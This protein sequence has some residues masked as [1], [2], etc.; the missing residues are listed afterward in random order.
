[1]DKIVVGHKTKFKCRVFTEK[2]L[3]EVGAKIEYLGRKIMSC[4]GEPG[5][6]A[7]SLKFAPFPNRNFNA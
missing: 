7:S 1:L 5:F 2:E 4:T 6:K 3:G